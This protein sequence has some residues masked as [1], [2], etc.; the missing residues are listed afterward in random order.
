KTKYEVNK[1]VKLASSSVLAEQN[2]TTILVTV[3]SENVSTDTKLDGIPLQVNFNEKLS[4][5]SIIPHQQ[6]RRDHLPSTHEILQGR[7]IDRAL[8]P[9]LPQFQNTAPKKIEINVDVLQIT[10]GV[11]TASLAL[12]AASLALETSGIK[13]LGMAGCV[14]VGFDAKNRNEIYPLVDIRDYMDDRSEMDLILAANEHSRLLMIEGACKMLD[15]KL[16]KDTVSQALELA[17]NVAQEL[18]E[19]SRKVER[20]LTSDEKVLL[21]NS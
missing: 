21:L 6:S 17:G 3:C 12:N 19:I 15:N 20:K 16:F 18:K 1:W 4:C 5:A 10:A 9:L 7:L 13:L 8:R 11:D 14:R 2:N